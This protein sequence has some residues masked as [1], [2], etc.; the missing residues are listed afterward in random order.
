MADFSFQ[1]FVNDFE[2]GTTHMTDAEVGC[3]LRLLLAQFRRGHLPN[4]NNFLKRFS[5]SFEES[6]PMVKEKF[7][8][9][10][11]GT[12]YNEKM[13]NV[14]IERNNYIESR[15]KNRKKKKDTNNTSKT[16]DEHMENISITYE[17][18]MDSDSDNGIDCNCH[19]QLEEEEIKINLVPTFQKNKIVQQIL[20]TYK[21]YYPNDLSDDQDGRNALLIA[22]YI[23]STLGFDNHAYEK[24]NKKEV[25]DYWNELL[26]FSITH[27]FFRTLTL[28]SFSI[29][30]NYNSLVKSYRD[31]LTP[32]TNG[33][34]KH[35]GISK[36]AGVSIKFD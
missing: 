12:L 21:D 31:S 19:G 13:K 4:D 20:Q 23:N 35:S 2:G 30:K 7:N 5:T 32:K 17:K 26:K 1:F 15:S 9:N 36:E 10:E 28:Q 11:D 14:R 33:N 34:G 22:V 16:Y 8:K 24:E 6:W 29:K 18:H 25:I 27:G 3:Y